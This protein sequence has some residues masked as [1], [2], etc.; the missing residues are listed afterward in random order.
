[1]TSVTLLVGD[2]IDFS[3]GGNYVEAG[4]RVDHNHNYQYWFWRYTTSTQVL[5]YASSGLKSGPSGDFNHDAYIAI[6]TSSGSTNTW[7][8]AIT[9][10]ASSWIPCCFPA[11][12][13]TSSGLPNDIEIGE[14]VYYSGYSTQDA[15]IYFTQNQYRNANNDGYYYQFQNGATHSDSQV[16]GVWSPPPSSS[17]TGGSFYTHV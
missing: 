11:H 17:S 8:A 5:E 1:M 13:S 14:R 4:Y 2:G 12:F 16:T 9:G 10:N 3:Q 7:H 6:Y 15:D